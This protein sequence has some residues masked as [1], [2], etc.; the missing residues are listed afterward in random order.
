MS[1][2]LPAALCI[3]GLGAISSPVLAVDSV[4]VNGQ[5]WYCTN[6]CKVT[7]RPDGSYNISDALGGR[8][9]TSFQSTP[10]AD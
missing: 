9:W 7:T 6:Q 8:I 10:P 2:K 4:T 1:K 5:K 3:V